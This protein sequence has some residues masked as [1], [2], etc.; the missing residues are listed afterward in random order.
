MVK[1]YAALLLL[2][3]A[4]ASSAAQ[5]AILSPQSSSIAGNASMQGHYG[6]YTLSVQQVKGAGE[7][8][9]SGAGERPGVPIEIIISGPEESHSALVSEMMWLSQNGVLST[10][11]SLE[12]VPEG[13][14][15]CNGNGEWEGAQAT[16]AGMGAGEPDVAPPSPETP[17]L[18]SSPEARQATSPYPS[19]EPTSVPQ[20]APA[21]EAGQLGAGKL[22]YDA[23]ATGGNAAPQAN[24]AEGRIGTEQ[25]L[26]LLGA[27][28]AV[29][30]VSYLVLHSRPAPIDQGDRLL[31]NE[32]RAGIMEELSSAD[33]IPTDLSLRLGKSK[34]SVVEHL[35]ALIEA[36]LV[37]RI[38]QPGKKFVY[39]RLTQKG[40]QLLLRRAG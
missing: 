8:S 12:K 31:A 17:M 38:A 1:A 30:V 10:K 23:Q 9:D 4:A 36:G 2:C 33:K 22:A 3:L 13:V 26:Q 20:P 28:I 34:A 18:P 35:S 32:T 15:Y 7:T 6:D 40:R 24:A 29:L 14:P 27:F 19:P 39:Y 21:P 37:E 25:M 11:C 16:A 5:V